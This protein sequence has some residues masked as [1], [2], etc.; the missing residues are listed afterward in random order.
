VNAEASTTGGSRSVG[1]KCSH[2][3]WRAKHYY[4]HRPTSVDE[5]HEVPRFGVELVPLQVIPFAGGGEP[6]YS[7]LRRGNLSPLSVR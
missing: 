4:Y 2:R 3:P 7:V 5:G 1:Q 6:P